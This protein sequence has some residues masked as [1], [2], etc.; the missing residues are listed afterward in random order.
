MLVHDVPSGQ[1]ACNAHFRGDS[2]IAGVEKD[3]VVSLGQ[4]SASQAKGAVCEN[5]VV[6]RRQQRQV[7]IRAVVDAR[8]CSDLTQ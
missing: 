8:P 1:A 4:K 2:V 3:G 5:G 7:L 6:A